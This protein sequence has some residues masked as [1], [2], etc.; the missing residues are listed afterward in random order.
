MRRD[1]GGA[2][3]GQVQAGSI[4]HFTAFAFSLNGF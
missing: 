2:E 4:K 1:V 3:H